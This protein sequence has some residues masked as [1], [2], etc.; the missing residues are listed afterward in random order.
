MKIL[1][2]KEKLSPIGHL[3]HVVPFFAT[4]MEVALLSAMSQRQSQQAYLQIPVLYI[5]GYT[6]DT[7]DL[8][9]L[10]FR[11][12][13]KAQ[14]TVYLKKWAFFC[15][16]NKISIMNASTQ[17]GCQ[18]LTEL[19]NKGLKYSSIN[20][21]RSALS[22]LLPRVNERTFGTI[23]EVTLVCRGASVKN[24]STGRYAGFW[25]V[26]DILELFQEWGDNR[27]L[28]LKLL[29]FKVSM[30]LLLVTAQRGQT[31]VNLSLE[32]AMIEQNEITFYM[33]TLLKHNRAGDS[34]D[35]ITVHAFEEDEDVC[36]VRALH[37]YLKK[38]KRLRSKDPVE[39][40]NS[41]LL[42]SHVSPHG[43]ISRDTLSHWTLGVLDLAGVNLTKFGRKKK[44][45]AH[46]TRGASTSKAK[47]LGVSLNMIMKRAGWRNASSFA[48]F[49]DKPI[50][51]N[52]AIFG[53]TILTEALREKE[54]SKKR[55]KSKK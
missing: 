15:I 27:E 1:S 12:S 11:K 4:S 6:K 33:N 54:K 32:G 24:P 28:S 36:V 37:R 17:Q 49:Y 16:R 50:E 22:S 39:S 43:P 21:A 25:D 20:T 7:V 48:K 8:I 46:S 31:I 38:T 40:K 53:Q 35:V 52:P 45:G 3:L 9:M 19:V 51:Q 2:G 26:T 14:Y 30:L 55:K 10:S 41:Q 34:M 44:F 29:S 13:T 5:A 47:A 18:F 42:I 23:H